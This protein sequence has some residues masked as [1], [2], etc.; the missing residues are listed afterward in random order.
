MARK[1]SQPFFNDAFRP[2]LE[3]GGDLRKKRRKLARPIDPKRAMHVTFRSEKAQGELSLLHSKNAKRVNQ[4]VRKIAARNGIRVYEYA[5]SGNHLHLLIRGKRRIDIQN[6]LRAIGS[7]VSQI[8]TGSTKG[9]AFGRFWDG[10]AYTRIVQWGR[11]FKNAVN[12]VLQNFF[13][14]E[15]VLDYM[16]RNPCKRRRP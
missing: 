16:P 9:Y 12:Y 13:E 8:V 15:G 10:L 7:R 4:E 2:R 3:H 11:D 5:N 6:F 14:A 1:P